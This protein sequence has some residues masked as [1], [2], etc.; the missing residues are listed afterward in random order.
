VTF[1]VHLTAQPI[2]TTTVTVAST[3]AASVSVAPTTLTFDAGNYLTDQVVTVTG[4]EDVN[5]A[6]EAVPINLTS[7]G[8]PTHSV[9]ATTT[10]NDTQAIVLSTTAITLAEGTKG[11]MTV[12]LA[13]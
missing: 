12:H 1:N 7:S 8:L 6:S 4:V 3:L 5:V 10:D 2:G 11:S 9:T 13:F